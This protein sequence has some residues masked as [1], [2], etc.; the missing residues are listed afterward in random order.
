VLD[1]DVILRGFTWGVADDVDILLTATQL[2]GR[3]AVVMSDSCGEQVTNLTLALDDESVAPLPR[4]N[5]P[6]GTFQPANNGANADTFPPP[7]PGNVPPGSSALSVF[8]GGNPNGTWQLFVVDDVGDLDPGQ[9]ERGWS[10]RIT[11]E[12]DVKKGK[13]GGSKGG[14][15]G[16][17]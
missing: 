15:R 8:D 16:R 1:V 12:V 5:C 4:A 11:A 7:G 14:K 2:P 9:I 3:Q 6:S 17:R 10:L 13:K